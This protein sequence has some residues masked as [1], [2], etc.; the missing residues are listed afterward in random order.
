VRSN[1][2]LALHAG[3]RGFES[4]RSRVLKC[5]RMG[6]LCSLLRRNKF[7]SSTPDTTPSKGLRFLTSR[8]LLIE[9]NHPTN[10]IPLKARLSSWPLELRRSPS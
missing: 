2:A 3:D 7:L 1:N 8:R 6:A 10:R 4:R 9:L 5:L